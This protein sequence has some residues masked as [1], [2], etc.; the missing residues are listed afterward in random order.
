MTDGSRSEAVHCEDVTARDAGSAT[1][2]RIGTFVANLRQRA[3]PALARAAGRVVARFPRGLDGITRVRFYAQRLTPEGVIEAYQLGL[4]P[5][6]DAKGRIHWLD[7]DPRGVIPIADFRVGSELRRTCRKGTFRVTV[8]RDFRGVIRG[9]AD[10]HMRRLKS[11]EASWVTPEIVDVYTELHRMCAA[12]S[13]EV[14][15]G[16]RLVGGVYGVSIGAYF[17]GESRFYLVS[18][19][20]QVAMA[21]L[22]HVLRAGGYLLHDAQ[23]ATPN[24][25]RFGCHTISK[26]EFR[27]QRIRAMLGS[28]RFEMTAFPPPDN[29]RAQEVQSRSSAPPVAGARPRREAGDRQDS[30]HGAPV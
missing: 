26:A 20:G 4:V 22:C 12:H 10:G 21:Y 30:P 23:M 19:A 18:G 3:V 16:E 7:F 6:T 1:S 24:L 27:A 28:A 11:G 13:V 29:A 5:L 15:Q 25:E 9:C 2:D 17:C 14:Y 8:N